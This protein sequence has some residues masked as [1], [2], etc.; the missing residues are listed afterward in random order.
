M[1]QKLCIDPTFTVLRC[2]PLSGTD[3]DLHG[4]R[5]SAVAEAVLSSP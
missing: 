5:R 3:C 4:S 1:S 2:V